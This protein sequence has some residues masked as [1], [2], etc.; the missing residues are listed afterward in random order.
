MEQIKVT[1]I[2]TTL[3]LLL[4]TI[5]SQA[6]KSVYTEKFKDNNGIFFTS[7]EFKGVKADGRTDVSDILQQAINRVKTERNFGVL[8]IPE[9]RYLITRT[10][11]VPAAIRLVGYG[12]TRPVFILGKET[13]GFSDQDKPNWMFW[14][15]S[16]I[17]NQGGQPSD[18]NAGT[19]YSGFSNID[20]LIEEGNPGAVGLRTHYAQHGVLSHC[21][22]NA[23][24]G[25]AGLTDVGNE[26][27]DVEFIG[28]R[29][30][31]A[32]G[33]PA[34]SWPMLIADCSFSGQTEAAISSRDAALTILSSSF[35]DA[36][37]GIVCEN[38]SEHLYVED[39]SFDNIGEVAILHNSA[40][41]P[42]NQVNVR[43]ASFRNVT[44]PVSRTT[45]GRGS[46]RSVS[47]SFTGL[48][49]LD[50]HFG[51]QALQMGEGSA[52]GSG[53]DTGTLTEFKAAGGSLP[54]LP[55]MSQWVSVTDFGAVGDGVTDDTEALRKAIE[56]AD[57][58]YFPEGWYRVSETLRMRHGTRM[59]GLHPYSTQII[60]TDGTPAFSGFGGPVAVVESSKGGD[61]VLTGIGISTGTYNYRAV[62]CKWMAGE[63]S[64]LNDVK[65]VGGHGTMQ[66]PGQAQAAR[67]GFGGYS[68]QGWDTQYWS[69]WITDGGGGTFK[70]I[71]TANTCATSGL[72]VSD[73]QTPSR[74]MAISLEHHQREESRFDNV[75]NFRI[76]AMQYEEESAEGKDCISMTLNKCRDMLFANTW[77]YRVIRVNTPRD[78][79]ILVT[80]CGD[81]DF[82]NMHCWTQVLPL[83]AATIYDPN[84]KLSVWPGDFARQR[85]TGN[86]R[87]RMPKGDAIMTGS[88]YE[89]ATGLTCDSKGNVY[90]CE[91]RLK[92]IYK[93]DATTGI[94]SL[95]ADFPWK[96][97]SLTVDTQDN[98]IVICRYD[99]QPG[100][101]ERIEHLPD[102]NPDYSG[103]GNGNWEARAY[104]ITGHDVMQ[105]LPLV[106]TSSVKAER[107]IHPSH[108][109]RPDFAEIATSM[110]GQSFLAADGVTIIPR[111]YDLG[112]T[113]QLTAVNPS[114]DKVAYV[115]CENNKSTYKFKVMPDGRLA[116]PESVMPHGDYGVCTSPDGRILCVAE[117]RLNITDNKTGEYT[118]YELDERPHSVVFGGAEGE[119]LFATTNTGLYRIKYK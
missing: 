114:R 62:A 84:R 39:C 12:K 50:M 53:Q 71:W 28:G 90:F 48:Y 92:K 37:Y 52:Y 67:Q 6:G 87:S 110:P 4:C 36:P 38:E 78:Y 42:T 100:L 93:W 24:S 11:H 9:G 65:F 76:Y 45:T 59:I 74:I 72:Y 43:G 33:R 56:S 40:I 15:T 95:V 46:E 69:L 32:T 108:R 91:N 17:V 30:G 31:I 75:R 105:P 10:I 85:I 99:P 3:C 55:D 22:I 119:Y 23:G 41:V 21:T 14:F 117:G 44:I 113:V 29:Y 88:G 19:F 70:D 83:T 54:L 97:F 58:L 82:Y 115:I 16:G 107:V 109:W 47:R 79:G 66:K 13:P 25:Y 27:E 63:G 73:T 5:G 98:L 68:Q 1:R 89:F 20:I 81:I 116:E 60:L 102:D 86:E 106:P 101:G 104:T 7:K 35:A 8:Y 80:D 77:L 112:R 49:K 96:P 61:N 26:M 111:T 103:W 51:F 18:A 57:N 118:Q 2:L 34:P 94:I 64:Y